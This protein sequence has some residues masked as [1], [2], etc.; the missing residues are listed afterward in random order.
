MVANGEMLHLTFEIVIV[1]GSGTMAQFSKHNEQRLASHVICFW[2]ARFGH[3]AISGSDG[4]RDAMQLDADASHLRCKQ[5]L[6]VQSTMCMS[7]NPCCVLQILDQTA[8]SRWGGT[9]QPPTG[10]TAKLDRAD[11]HSTSRLL[12]GRLLVWWVPHHAAATRARVL[13]SP[14]LDSS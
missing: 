12:V 4:C 7:Y 8:R 11:P 9:R 3:F 14:L 1:S 10:P 2:L 13:I 5:T 6:S